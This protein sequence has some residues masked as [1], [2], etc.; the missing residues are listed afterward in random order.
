[1]PVAYVAHTLVHMAS[2]PLDVNILNQVSFS[3]PSLILLLDPQADPPHPCRRL[4]P[5]LCLSLDVVEELKGCV[6]G[7]NVSYPN[8]SEDGARGFL[9]ALPSGWSCVAKCTLMASIIAMGWLLE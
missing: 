4:W 2:F 9:R 8:S 7:V 3:F 6:A 1:M 5:P